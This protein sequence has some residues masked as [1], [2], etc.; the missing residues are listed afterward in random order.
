MSNKE[1]EDF[2]LDWCKRQADGYLVTSQTKEE[3]W[4]K[5]DWSRGT[6]KSLSAIAKAEG[7]E[8]EDW[9]AALKACTKCIKMGWPWVQH[10]DLTERW[11][12]LWFQRGV[13]E[14][15]SK[16]WRIFETTQRSDPAA[17]ANLGI[18]NNG[19]GTLPIGQPVA[20]EAPLTPQTSILQIRI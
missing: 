4:R 6:Y 19:T 13:N 3:E 11:D 1:K 18:Q 7:G 8:P 10:N 12:Y 2:R 17:D 15:L 14:T 16:S 9:A 20:V 5:V